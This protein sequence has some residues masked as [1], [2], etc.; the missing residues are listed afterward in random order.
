M[1]LCGIIFLVHSNLYRGFDA[2]PYLSFVVGSATDFSYPLLQLHQLGQ[3]H[4][5]DTIAGNV[6][7][8]KDYL[9]HQYIQSKDT[10]TRHCPLQIIQATRTSSFAP[11]QHAPIFKLLSHQLQHLH[12]KQPSMIKRPSSSRESSQPFSPADQPRS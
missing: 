4:Q 1:C 2:F 7:P 6:P 10:K 12:D 8:K 9:H 3:H 5:R 11:L